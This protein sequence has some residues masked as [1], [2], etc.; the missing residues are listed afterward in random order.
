MKIKKNDNILVIKGKD[1]NKKGKV[2][3]VLPDAEK[4]IVGGINLVK[5]HQKPRRGGE[6]GKTVTVESP[7][8]IANV[9]IICTKCG[10]ATRVGY[11]KTDN[12]ETVRICKKCDQ[13]I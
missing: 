8:R 13:E 6:K 3:T 7:L 4:V 10:K 11:K 12:G 9:A 2:L 5:K 1:R